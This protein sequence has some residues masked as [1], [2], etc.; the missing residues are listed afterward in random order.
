M[1]E[2]VKYNNQFLPH[3]AR[4]FYPKTLKVESLLDYFRQTFALYQP[5][6]EHAC[7]LAK[8]RNQL[9]A[10]AH[11]ASFE[12]VQ[13]GLIYVFL[14]VDK[15]IDESVFASFW[16]HC[17]DLARS[18][19]TGL[20][21]FRV[22]AAGDFLPAL[23]ERQGFKVVSE[24]IEMHA[25]LGQLPPDQDSVDD[26]FS[27]KTLAQQPDLER[28][29]LDTFNQGITAFWDIPPLDDSCFKRMHQAA[30][31]D[32]D[33][34][35]L[36]FSAD[37]AVAAQFYSVIDC[38]AGIV[39]LYS[40]STPSSK[41][42]RGYGRRM[43]KDALNTLEAKGFSTAVVYADA[44]SQATALLYKMLGF[45]PAGAVKILESDWL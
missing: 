32:P 11:M 21:M 35:R 3:I 39:R 18:N 12:K 37:E 28:Q 14:A 19:L 8:N 30:T 2:V 44:A 36:G 24:Q 5:D 15:R 6:P 43:L 4:L 26:D 13:P 25:A 9:L 17:R 16:Q 33:V 31:C 42:S 34:F 40:A 23:L 29:W 45:Q 27:V 41:R 22:A 7:L 20:M 1:A 38:D 10:C